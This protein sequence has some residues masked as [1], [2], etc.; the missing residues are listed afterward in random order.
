MADKMTINELID[1]IKRRADSAKP[2]FPD[3][4]AYV[5]GCLDTTRFIRDNREAL[6]A[7]LR[8]PLRFTL[9]SIRYDNIG[10]SQVK[11]QAKICDVQVVDNY[12]YH[13][14]STH[15]I[16]VEMHDKDKCMKAAQKLANDLGMTAEFE[17]IK[18]KEATNGNKS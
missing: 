9:R 14:Y 10:G 7:G 15:L 11:W 2:I 1:T 16:G 18:E 8:V 5:L 3:E 4:Q 17:I 6:E 13:A 12:H